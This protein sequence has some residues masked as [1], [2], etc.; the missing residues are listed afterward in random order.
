LDIE[1]FGKIPDIPQQIGLQIYRF[2]LKLSTFKRKIINKISESTFFA[3]MESIFYFLKAL[4]YN[5]EK[6]L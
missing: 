3:A 2:Y 4:T 1:T 6:Y 5:Y